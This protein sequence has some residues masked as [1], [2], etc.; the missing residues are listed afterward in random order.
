[1]LAFV[2]LLL[3]L[4]Q[5]ELGWM[6]D[7]SVSELAKSLGFRVCAH[8]RVCVRE[9]ERERERERGGDEEENR[10]FFTVALTVHWKEASGNWRAVPLVTKQMLAVATSASILP[11]HSSTSS[12]S[13]TL[14]NLPSL[15]VQNPVFLLQ[16]TVPC[17]MLLLSTQ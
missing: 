11:A 17:L 16:D 3:L 13:S 10:V 4:L 7:H 2:L 6:Q 1:M 15:G 12:T 5:D 14:L 8:A 9:R